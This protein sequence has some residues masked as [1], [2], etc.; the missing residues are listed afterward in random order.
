VSVA[1]TSYVWEKSEAE[2]ADR[3]VLLALADFA[4]ENGNCFG[5]WGKLEQK[6]RLSRATVARCL[7]RL[8]DSG[9]LVMVE[10][11]HRRIAGNGAEATVWRIA[12]LSSEMGLRLRPVSSCDPSSVRMRPKWCQD[13]T[14]TISNNKEHLLGDTPAT[15]SPSHPPKKDEAATGAP[16]SKPRKA[17][18]AAETVGLDTFALPFPSTGFRKWWGEFIEFRRGKIRG[19]HNPLTQ[20]AAAIILDELSM[21]NEWQAVEAIKAAIACAYI[22]PYTDKYRDKRGGVHNPQPLPQQTSGPSALERS[23]HRVRMEVAA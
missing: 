15:P 22:K 10:K 17:K 16:E 9:D 8:Q 21:V 3:L 12:G 2:G 5:S 4:D 1:A 6:T 11:G 20:R 14:P 18:V 13:E 23:L 7:R 19:R